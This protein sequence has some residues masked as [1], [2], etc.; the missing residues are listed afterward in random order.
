MNSQGLESTSREAERCKRIRLKIRETIAIFM[1][2]V[3][4]NKQTK[5]KI[6]FVLYNRSFHYV[7]LYF[8]LIYYT[9]ILLSIFTQFYRISSFCFC[10]IQKMSTN[11][12]TRIG[13]RSTLAH[14]YILDRRI[15]IC[16]LWRSSYVRRCQHRRMMNKT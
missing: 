10:S 7:F 11:C 2:N 9:T 15:G 5:K 12:S 8:V 3:V 6:F 16:A 4:L 14:V 1:T 13:V